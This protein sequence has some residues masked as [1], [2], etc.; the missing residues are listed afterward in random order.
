M[1]TEIE[2]TKKFY[3]IVPLEYFKIH[4]QIRGKA[5]FVKKFKK[6]FSVLDGTKCQN[7]VMIDFILEPTDKLLEEGWEIGCIG[8]EIKSSF[9]IEKIAGR[10]LCQILDYQSCMY[11]L[12]EMTTELSM[13]FLY[14]YRKTYHEVS[15]IMQQEGLGFVRELPEYGK[16]FQLLQANSNEPVFSLLADGDIEIRRPRYGKKFGHR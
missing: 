15:S 5:I 11:K 12:P 3:Q 9:G 14:P 7:T 6:I 1:L 4:K 16:A 10:A 13:I 8:I 2:A